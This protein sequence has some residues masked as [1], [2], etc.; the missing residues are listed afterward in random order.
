MVNSMNLSAQKF[1]P[2]IL[3]Y[4]SI[5]EQE[6]KQTVN[7]KTGTLGL[8]EQETPINQTETKTATTLNITKTYWSKKI[9]NSSEFK[10]NIYF[11]LFFCDQTYFLSSR[12]VKGAYISGKGNAGSFEVRWVSKNSITDTYTYCPGNKDFEIIRNLRPVVTLN[13]NVVI[14]SGEGTESSAY[15]IGL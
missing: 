5:L 12:C 8:S 10:N 15:E 4:P 14:K 1:S 3:V 9:E 11:S 13:S 7:G 2:D 6:E